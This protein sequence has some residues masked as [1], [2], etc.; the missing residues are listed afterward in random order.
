M[1]GVQVGAVL[2]DRYEL[3]AELGQGGMGTVYRA[4]DPMLDRQVAI[5]VLTAARLGTEGRVLR[6]LQ[7]L[8]TD[9]SER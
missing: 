1:S 3:K 5:K 6:A 4:R 7:E 8:P 2:R 9:A